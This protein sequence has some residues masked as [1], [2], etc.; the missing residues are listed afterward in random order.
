MRWPLQK[1]INS[2][3]VSTAVR[4]LYRRAINLAMSIGLIRPSVPRGKSSISQ[5]KHTHPQ[6]LDLLTQ[7]AVG[8]SNKHKHKIH[9]RQAEDSR[10]NTEKLNG[11]T[12]KQHTDK[13]RVKS[14]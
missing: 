6:A 8:R 7:S 4:Y 5:W 9:A 1:Q 10:K 11:N 12:G 3:I 13:Q 2:K 14:I